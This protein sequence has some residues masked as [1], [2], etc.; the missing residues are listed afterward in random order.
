LE[1]FEILPI[2]TIF[3]VIITNQVVILALTL[4]FSL[5]ANDFEHA[6]FA[7]IIPRRIQVIIE[8]IYSMFLGMTLDNINGKHNAAFFLLHSSLFRS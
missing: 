2:Y 4:F 5:V 7:F 3:F 8:I 6:T 1:Q